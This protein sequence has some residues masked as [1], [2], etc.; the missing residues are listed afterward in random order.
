MTT[1]PRARELHRPARTVPAPPARTCA[2][3]GAT[4]EERQCKI[5][6]LNCGARD[7]CT[8]P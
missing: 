1:E 4:M 5:V 3:C 8:D 7:D 6:C 2:R